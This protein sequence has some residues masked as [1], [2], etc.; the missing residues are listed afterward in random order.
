MPIG[1]KIDEIGACACIA[2]IKMAIYCPLGS[3]TLRQQL[4][5]LHILHIL[6]IMHILHIL[7]IPKGTLTY[8]AMVA[9]S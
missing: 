7:H 8:S 9:L 6:H 1:P 2:Y 3:G 5:L 4:T